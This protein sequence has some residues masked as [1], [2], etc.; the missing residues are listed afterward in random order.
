MNTIKKTIIAI[1]A[2]SALG[3]SSLATA[4]APA[5]TSASQEIQ[6]DTQV[7]A[8]DLGVQEPGILPNSPFYFIKEWA[9]GITNF[10]TFDA[11][12]KAELASKYTNEKLIELQKLAEK[13]AS[14]KDVKDAVTNYQNSI[15]DLKNKIDQVPDKT[16]NNRELTNFLNDFTKHQILQ[17][18]ALRTII[19]DQVSTDISNTIKDAQDAQIKNFGAVVSDLERSKQNVRQQITDALKN[20]PGSQF[21]DFSNL[22]L[23]KGLEDSVS[24]GTKQILQDV[25]D[26]VQQNLQESL[27]NLPLSEQQK[28][29]DYLQNLPGEKEIYSNVLQNLSTGTKDYAEFTRNLINTEETLRN[30]IINSTLKTA[31]DA[32]NNVQLQIQDDVQNQIQ[33]NPLNPVPD[34]GGRE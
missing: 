27:K 29:A 9:R 25:A 32:N 12:K 7:T 11:T 8:Q 5:T 24:T 33:P 17:E 10:F 26:T 3:T 34:P 18:K 16:T 15:N 31:E 30:S 23:L 4:Q 2:V 20:A 14:A 6:A 22:E 21:K 1:L 13:N 19:T 28:I